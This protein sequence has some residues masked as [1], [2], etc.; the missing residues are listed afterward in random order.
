VLSP[1][2][3]AVTREY[4][5][6][7]PHYGVGSHSGPGERVLLVKAMI[8]ARP[9]KLAMRLRLPSSAPLL[10]PR[11]RRAQTGPDQTGPGDDLFHDR[12]CCRE[13]I[14]DATAEL[15]YS[16]AVFLT[17]PSPASPPAPCSSSR[18]ASKMCSE[19]T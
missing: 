18:S 1:N 9:S 11:S 6:S 7:G 10:R 8:A 15:T 4:L 13:A 3:P 16:T 14:M 19:P 2:N 5:V 12:V 17:R